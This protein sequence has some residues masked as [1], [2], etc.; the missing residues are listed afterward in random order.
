MRLCI[1]Y[2]DLS[3]MLQEQ[4]TPQHYFCTEAPAIVQETPPP[5]RSCLRTR[6]TC[7][8]TTLKQKVII[9]LTIPSHLPFLSSLPL[10]CARRHARLVHEGPALF[11]VKAHHA[12]IH[13][14]LICVCTGVETLSHA[15]DM[16]S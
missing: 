9:L 8:F 1:F 5:Y 13:S 12:R 7:D 11:K 16:A 4:M 10:A 3:L 2:P 6:V 14:P 15:T